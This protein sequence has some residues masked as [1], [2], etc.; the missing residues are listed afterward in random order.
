MVT[1]QLYTTGIG[2]PFRIRLALKLFNWSLRLMGPALVQEAMCI[3]TI[4]KMQELAVTRQPLMYFLGDK[5]Y[6]LMPPD[7]AIQ[8]EGN[9]LIQ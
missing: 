1:P 9:D 6:A 3:F 4:L 2:L 5:T 7:V 8:Q